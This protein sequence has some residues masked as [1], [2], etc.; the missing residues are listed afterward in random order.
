MPVFLG[1]QPLPPSSKPVG[2]HLAVSDSDP[3]PFLYEDPVMMLSSP[4]DTGQSPS[5]DPSF[6]PIH[7]GH[8]LMGAGGENVDITGAIIQP[9]VGEIIYT[10]FLSTWP[11]QVAQW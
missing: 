5:R 10:L 6:T 11:S 2:Q 3:L 7:E 4:D 9:L 8:I 1:L